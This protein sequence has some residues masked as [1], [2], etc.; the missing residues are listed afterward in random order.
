MKPAKASF[1]YPFA[2]QYDPNGTP[3]D[4]KSTEALLTRRRRV[5]NKIISPLLPKIRKASGAGW[6]QDRE[7]TECSLDAALQDA[8]IW[9]GKRVSSSRA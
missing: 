4:A 9:R 3:V 1:T 8:R 6:S 7:A 2:F 5:S